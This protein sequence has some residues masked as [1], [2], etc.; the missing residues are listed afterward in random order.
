MRALRSALTCAKRGGAPEP[1]WSPSCFASGGHVHGS[2]GVSAITDHR[3]GSV[4][5]K[6]KNSSGDLS[7]LYATTS[8]SGWSA[9]EGW[10]SLCCEPINGYNEHIGK[11]EHICLHM[12]YSAVVAY[13]RRWDPV[14]V[15]QELEDGVS[16]PCLALQH[17][18]PDQPRRPAPRRRGKATMSAAMSQEL[19]QLTGLP[20]TSPLLCVFSAHHRQTPATHRVELL[21]TLRALQE[22][23]ILHVTSARFSAAYFQGSVV[24][25]K[26]LFP[27]LARM[28]PNA[29]AKDLSALTQVIAA[30]YNCETLFDLCGLAQILP[31]ELATAQ[32]VMSIGVEDEEDCSRAEEENGIGEESNRNSS[33]RSVLSFRLKSAFVRA[34]IGELRWSLESETV[35]PP[36]AVLTQTGV[37]LE[38]V[39]CIAAHACRLLI[40]ELINC[41]VSEYIVRVASI[42]TEPHGLAAMRQRVFG[43][44][45]VVD[46]H[47]WRQRQELGRYNNDEGG[48]C[49]EA[50]ADRRH[51]TTQRLG[52]W[53]TSVVPQLTNWGMCKY[54]REDG[55]Y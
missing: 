43:G 35:P 47:Q 26:E 38:V 2:S 33:G 19:H 41:K 13:E 21:Q 37:P 3:T 1:I 40:A 8:S 10:C 50:I 18:G 14:E 25:F 24:L 6:R 27:P 31:P 49:T 54:V 16:L 9:I 42:V 36:T 44:C 39:R 29:A 7:H 34:I 46:D 30:S 17:T 12:I 28:F 52:R 20:A 45:L 4:A 23:G 53:D 5:A 15:W 32:A 51:R 11:R 48:G 55:C 22:R